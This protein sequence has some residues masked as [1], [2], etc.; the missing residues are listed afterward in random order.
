MCPVPEPGLVLVARRTMMVHFTRACG[1][2][3]RG[4]LL[5]ELKCSI[6]IPREQLM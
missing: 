1:R 5:S 4:S 6:D 2:K 3:E